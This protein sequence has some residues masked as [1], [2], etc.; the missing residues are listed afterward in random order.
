MSRVVTS[1]C[2]PSVEPGQPCVDVQLMDN[3][4]QIRAFLKEVMDWQDQG[5]RVATGLGSVRSAG[6][7][8]AV[9]WVRS[10]PC[11]TPYPQNSGC[12]AGRNR[13]QKDGYVQERGRGSVYQPV[14]FMSLVR[15]KRRRG[16]ADKVIPP[17]SCVRPLY[18]AI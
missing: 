10:R 1:E 11:F 16:W 5:G 17:A 8:P 18:E 14:V 6:T 12:P 3:E 7:R 9:R 15:G 2:C 4:G 13:F